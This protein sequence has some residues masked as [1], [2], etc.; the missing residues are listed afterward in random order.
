MDIKCI[1]T[2]CIQLKYYRS[3]LASQRLV[4]LKD[5][6][7]TTWKGVEWALTNLNTF[8]NVAYMD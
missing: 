6:K 2:Y 7:H 1:Y 4:F 5:Q 8:D 3:L